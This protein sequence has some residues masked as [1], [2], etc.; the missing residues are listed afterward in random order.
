MDQPGLPTNIQPPVR[1][2]LLACKVM[3]DEIALHARGASHIVETRFF[4]IGLHDRPDHLRATLQEN[5]EAVD[6]RTDIEAV[7]LAYG[8]CGLGTAG[9]RPK[10]HKLVIPRAHDCIT[11]FMG[12]KERYADHQRR[13]PSCYYYTPG[14]NQARRVPGP[15]LFENLREDLATRY[16]EEDLEFLLEAQRELYAQHD[17]ATYINLGTDNAAEEAAYARRCADWLGWKFEQRPGDPALLRD[18]LWG[19]WDS[20]RF[21]VI[22]PGQQVG[23]AAD[24]SIMRAEPAPEPPH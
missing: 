5:L 17:T 16:D 15:E 24:E 2:A 8:L 19:N 11:L 6:A 12:S 20:E 18:L 21:L 3:E 22:D 10:H 13:C 14:W 9:L 23:Q 1:V 7:V 4:E